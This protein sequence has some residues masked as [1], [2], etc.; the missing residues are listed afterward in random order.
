[1]ELKAKYLN[2]LVSEKK[3]EWWEKEALVHIDTFLNQANS[4]IEGEK[5]TRADILR[6]IKETS[7]IPHLGE[8]HT[9][10]H[11]GA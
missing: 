2:A 10:H 1:G 11:F 6:I 9:L 8:T 3:L 5:L 7:A 4:G